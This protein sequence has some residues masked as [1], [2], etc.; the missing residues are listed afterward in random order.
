M[1]VRGNPFCTMK[2]QKEFIIF[3]LRSLNI[4]NGEPVTVGWRALSDDRFSQG[5]CDLA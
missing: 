1:E 4:L 2:H 5:M 3:Y